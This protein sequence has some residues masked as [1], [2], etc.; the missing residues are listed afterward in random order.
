[1]LY[2]LCHGHKICVTDTKFV[3]STNVG[4]GNNVFLFARAFTIT[5]LKPVIA[6]LI[7]GPVIRATFFFNLS[8]NIVPVQVETLCCAY[9]RR[10]DQLVLGVAPWPGCSVPDSANQV[11]DRILL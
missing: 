5:T 1:M 3:S 9:Y 2:F 8:C 11:R 7:K 4:V 6:L 10:R